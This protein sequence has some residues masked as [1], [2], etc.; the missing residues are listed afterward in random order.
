MNYSKTCA[1]IGATPE[2][3]SFGYDEEHP[4][5]I[6]IKKQ[7]ASSILTLIENGYDRF[8]S[9]LSEGVEMWG[10]EVC[11]AIRK[12]G[13]PLEL[14]CVPT[15]EEQAN[16]WYPSVRERYFNLLE[17]CSEVVY[18]KFSQDEP[19]PEDRESFERAEC[20]R[21]ILE[22][23]DAILVIEPLDDR[24]KTLIFQA[25]EKQIPIIEAK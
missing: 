12:S 19:M 11:A 6:L 17:H 3:L 22:N 1:I 9:S 25:K 24:A 7:L 8:V 15:F 10:A 5:A 2:V 18:T 13:S 21:Y 4:N 20:D 14:I 16:R 23:S